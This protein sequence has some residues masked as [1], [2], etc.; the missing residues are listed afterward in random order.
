MVA[1][2]HT[3]RLRGRIPSHRGVRHGMNDPVQ[4]IPLAGFDPE[5]EPEIRVMPDGSWY[6][7]FNFMPPSWAEDA[8]RPFGDFDRQLAQAVGLPVVWEDREF[9]RIERPGK[10]TVERIRRFLETYRRS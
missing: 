6:V 2:G 5:G 9:F 4:V 8:P 7:V 1:A 3:R 10:D